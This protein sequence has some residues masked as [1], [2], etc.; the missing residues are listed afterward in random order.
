MDHD[1]DILTNFLEEFGVLNEGDEIV[2]MLNRGE[3][4]EDF[5]SININPNKE[6]NAKIST[7]QKILIKYS[8]SDNESVFWSLL[9]DKEIPPTYFEVLSF[10]LVSH[11]SFFEYGVSLYSILLGMEPATSLWNP[12]LFSPILKTLITSQQT[13][14]NGSKLT[15]Q[16]KE[17]LKLTEDILKYLSKAFTENFSNMIGYEVLIALCEISIKLMVIFRVEFDSFNMTISKEA[18]K[19]A[20][21]IADSHLDLLLPFLVPALLLQFA[22]SS[23]SFTSRLERIRDN[24]LSFTLSLLKPDDQRIVLVCKHL[25]MRVPEKAHLRKSASYVILSLTKNSINAKDIISFANKLGKSTKVGLRAFSSHLLMTYL[26]NITDL[27]PLLGD[28]ASEIAIESASVIQQQLSD[29]APTIRAAALESI[30]SIIENLEINPF[31][32]VIKHII[33]SSGSLEKI[34]KKR[35]IDEKLIVR[36]AALQCLTQIITCNAK[37]LTSTM[38]DLLTS[39]TLDR[40]VSMRSLAIKSLNLSLAKFPDN[41]SLIHAW[42]NSVLPLIDDPENSV[43]N[44]AFEAIRTVLINPLI[45]NDDEVYKFEEYLSMMQPAHFDFIQNSIRFFKQKNISLD[46]LCNTIAKRIKT[47]DASEPI[48]KLADILSAFYTPPFSNQKFYDLWNS[49]EQLP[50]EY[51]SIL[52]HLEIQTDEI[53]S[54]CTKL[55]KEEISQNSLRYNLIHCIIELLAVQLDNNSVWTQMVNYCL[56]FI[57]D[58]T[59]NANAT[60]DSLDSLLTAIYT[61]GEII[62]IS[63]KLK[64]NIS[65][66]IDF[67]G[68]KLLIS[69]F[70]PNQEKISEKVRALT[71][72]SL[73]KLCIAQK[74]VSRSFISAFTHLLSNTETNPAIKCNCLLVLYDLCTTYSALVDPHI[75]LMVNCIIDESPL[76]RHQIIHVLTRLIIEDFLKMNSIMFFRFLYALIDKN[77]SVSSFARSCLFNVI[78]I[79]YPQCLKSYFVESLIYFSREIPLDALMETEEEREL[80]KITDKRLRQHI[81]ALM[82]SRMNEITTFQIIENIC[83][84]ILLKFVNGAY[85]LEKH[86]II[87]EDS[88]FSLNELEDKMIQSTTEI[89]AT[90]ENAEVLD[91]IFEDTRKVLINSHN[92]MIQ[93]VLPTLNALHRILREK[94]S[95]LQSQLKKFYQRLLLKNPALSQQLEKSEPLLVAELKREM[96]STSSEEEEENDQIPHTPRRTSVLFESPLLS[97]IAST[98]KSLL[99]TPHSNNDEIIY[100]TP[101]RTQSRNQFS[102]PPHDPTILD[103]L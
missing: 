6:N 65:S 98:P 94:H 71:V 70:L 10:Y 54:D 56:S 64:Q 39:R 37:V 99:C 55:L 72:I 22:V 88:I 87:L 11:E 75:R 3:I 7:I 59:E 83:Q 33:D 84:N 45:Q 79:K 67:T 17:Q 47:N 46:S 25:M 43:Q 31:G 101:K 30:T 52:S 74:S 28:N 29:Q 81:L 80:F 77:Y 97:K 41:Q 93:S 66:D 91:K 76:V 4:S 21:K 20:L 5:G 15:P 82:I 58:T 62:S 96:E 89:E 57:N 26:V 69:D 85:S 12:T 1:A 44:E 48:W 73:G 36:R 78:M 42:L 16:V 102:T 2:R 18:K 51:F 27:I 32:V 103:D 60:E 14:E 19:L 95:P 49:I 90:Y 92:V 40:A 9:R 23:S 100:S 35:I 61:I 68:L 13:L 38:I 8:N 34:L 63:A 53:T 50:P 24:I 86:F